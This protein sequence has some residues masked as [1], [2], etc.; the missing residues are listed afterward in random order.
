MRPIALRSSKTDGRKALRGS[1]LFK[2]LPSPGAMPAQRIKTS[3]GSSC[4][5]A[6]LAPRARIWQGSSN[7]AALGIEA[8][9]LELL[10]HLKVEHA[11]DLELFNLNA[12]SIEEEE[13]R[14]QSPRAIWH[15]DHLRV[16][17]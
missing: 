11:I 7:L 17:R 15:L 1:G 14:A 13:R 6:A 16:L 8:A 12:S 9:L 4:S 2:R 5:S 10:H 3:A